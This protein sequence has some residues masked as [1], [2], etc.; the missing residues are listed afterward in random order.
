MKKKYTIAGTICESSDVLAKNIVLPKQNKDDYLIIHDTGAYGAVMASN[1]NSRGLP[2][3][4]LVN[5][6][7][8]AVIYKPQTIEQRI[9]QDIIP[10]W[11]DSS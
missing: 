8:F 4:I 1:Y 3:E 9:D 2:T 10:S 5:N 7:S 11:L 6:S